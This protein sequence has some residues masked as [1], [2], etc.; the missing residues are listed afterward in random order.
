VGLDLS[1]P[2]L[3][4][5]YNVHLPA[6]R[7]SISAAVFRGDANEWAFGGGCTK[8]TDFVIIGCGFGSPGRK[9]RRTD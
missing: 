7:E 8:Y 2:R 9:S 4:S 1:F 6:N 5:Y 3:V